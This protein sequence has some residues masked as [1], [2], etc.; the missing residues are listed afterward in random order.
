[1]QVVDAL[2][3]MVHRNDAIRVGRGLCEKMRDLLDRQQFEVIIQV[4]AHAVQHSVLRCDRCDR[5]GGH[6]AQ[7]HLADMLGLRHVTGM[8]A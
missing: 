8:T 7:E 6:V 5:C 4:G 3:R 1:M 2:A